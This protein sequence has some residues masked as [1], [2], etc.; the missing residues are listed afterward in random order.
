MCLVYAQI[1]RKKV[2][3]SL[4]QED[5][6]APV[7]AGSSQG[8]VVG[9][10][11]IFKDIAGIE[12]DAQLTKVILQP[13]TLGEAMLQPFIRL[14]D[15]LSE[16][17]QGFSSNSSKLLDEGLSSAAKQATENKNSTTS[18]GLLAAGGVAVAALGSSLAFIITSLQD[19][20]LMEWIR[21]SLL[22]ILAI[23]I[24]TVIVGWLKLRSRN[25]AIVLE[26]A[27]W[28]LNDDL[29]LDAE[30]GS[31]FTRRPLLPAGAK[32]EKS[33]VA[34]G[35]KLRRQLEGAEQG[36]DPGTR[37]ALL[38]LLG[39][40]LLLGAVSYWEPLVKS[41]QVYELK[42]LQASGDTAEPPR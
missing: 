18:T 38:V 32:I 14:K 36:E 35:L 7:T 42:I 24:P 30:V 26:G 37:R 10:R 2:D 33:R 17:L 13:V 21:G 12:Y 9:K 28:A 8:M 1:S 27:G 16:R 29:L 15:Q 34:E 5:I 23:L 41:L 11:G 22:V 31:L 6:V 4:M 39:L 19:I 20:S 3:G 40:I 25:L